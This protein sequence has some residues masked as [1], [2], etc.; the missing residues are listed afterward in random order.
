MPGT[1]QVAIPGFREGAIAPQRGR[2]RL[3]GLV[4]IF[5]A[6]AL[7]GAGGWWGLAQVGWWDRLVSGGGSDGSRYEVR[8][9]DMTITLAET[10]ELKP[11][12]SIE[13]RCEVE[14]ESTLRWIVP[15]SKAVTKGELLVELA[16]DELVEKLETETIETRRAQTEFEAATETLAIQLNKNTSEIRQAEIALEIAEL[17]LKRYLEGEHEKSLKSARIDIEQTEMDILQKEDELRKSEALHEKGF[18][19]ESKLEELRFALKKSRM[20]L[21]K[22]QLALSILEAYD[23]P[24]NQKQ[25]QSDVDRAREELER[26]RQQANSLEKQARALVEERKSLL[27]LRE[28]RLERARRAVGKA[29]IYAPMDGVVK[30][31]GED[32]GMRWGSSDRLAPGEKVFEGQVLLVLPDTS[33]MIVSSRIH[34][35]DRHKVSEGLRC[36]V[37]VPAVPNQVFTGKLSK[38]AQFADSAHRWFNPELKE[39]TVEIL[40]DDTTAPV[41]PGDTAQIEIQIETLKGVLAVPVQCVFT[42]G[43]KSYVFV[44]SGGQPQAREVRLGRAST[45]FVEVQEGIAAGDL[46][47]QHADDTML[48]LLPAAESKSDGSPDAGA[49]QPRRGGRGPSRAGRG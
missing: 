43:R 20:E 15:E 6:L 11:L 34:E 22:N 1:P 32:G 45:Q 4:L 9:I 12:N 28:N 19:T 38:I 29:K 42:R 8:P 10:G 18:V 37:R 5:L 23:H 35:A 30:Y 24:K 46:V 16:S 39:H 7:L 44:D 31:A 41:S 3:G 13:I 27:A 25:K 47:F 21:E 33:K 2:S 48:A 40:L 36:L 26:V 49:E 17:E 14:G